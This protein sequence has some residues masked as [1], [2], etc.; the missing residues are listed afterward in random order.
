M[1]DDTETARAS[2]EPRH[3]YD[4]GVDPGEARDPGNLVNILLF[5][6]FLGVGGGLIW[7]RLG[8]SGGATPTVPDFL[9]DGPE[10]VVDPSLL[11]WEE[12]GSFSTGLTDHVAMQVLDNGYIAVIGDRR[13]RTFAGSGRSERPRADVELAGEPTGLG[14]HEDTI[15]VGLRDRVAMYGP[16]GE[17]RG[18]LP[19]PAEGTYIASVVVRGGETWCA[20]AANLKLWRYG[21]DGKPV[22]G[23]VGEQLPGDRGPDWL[24]LPEKVLDTDVGS[25]GELYVANAGRQRIEIYDAE[26]AFI[27]SVGRGGFDIGGFG[28]CHNPIAFDLVDDGTLLTVEKGRARIKLVGLDGEV[29]E[30]VALPEDFV[31][32]KSDAV[33]VQ[34]HPDGDRVLILDDTRNLV[35]IFGRKKTPVGGD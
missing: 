24:L 4:R 25:E 2:E 28:G 5:V 15:Y 32:G 31:S 13:L 33:D 26:N 6:G 7:W 11:R 27:G 21:E 16:R 12:T 9:D 17:P 18:E 35:R 3:D 14:Q 29:E 34:Y 22:A 19:G 10:E 23:F 20:D 30:V 1:A 8:P